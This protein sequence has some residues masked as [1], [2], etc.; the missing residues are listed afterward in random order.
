MELRNLTRLRAKNYFWS[1]QFRKRQWDGYIY[2]IT[3]IRAEFQTGLLDEICTHLEEMGEKFKITDLRDKFKDLHTF[4]G[5]GNLKYRQYQKDSINAVLNHRVRGL[6]FPRG[7]LAEAT[8]AGKSLIAAGIYASFSKKRRGL[9]LVNSKTL[10]VQTI[11]DLKELLPGEIGQVNADKVDWKRI[12][13]CMVQ[14][15]GNRLQKDPKLRAELS[16]MDIVIVDEGDELIGRKDCQLVLKHCFNAPIR[17]C[18]SGS[19]LMSKDKNRNKDQIKYF[20]PII[21]SISNKEL[22][23]QGYSTPPDIRM[24]SGNKHIVYPGDYSRE[25]L[26]GIITNRRRNKIVWRLVNN[27]LKKNRAPILILFKI[28][29]HAENLIKVCPKEISQNYKIEVVHHKTANREDIFERFNSGKV[30]ICLASMIIKRGKN[31]PLIKTLI[32]AA[33]GDSQA[34]VLQIMGRSLRSHKSKR[35]V[36]LLDFWDEG[37]YLKRHSKH[38]RIYYKAQKFEVKELYNKKAII[39]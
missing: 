30:E 2:Y 32:N 37:K 17:I 21:H 31:L 11:K 27:Y 35:K 36:Y 4:E 22:V 28:H 14:T 26:E 15:L 38:R 1:P 29:E 18:L 19:P 3:E 6:K 39:K 12:N 9:F 13:V 25:Y 23:D 7:I 20:G 8:N 5:L 24:Y 16:K 10:F 33:G 34:N